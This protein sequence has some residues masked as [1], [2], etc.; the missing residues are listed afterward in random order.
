MD[1]MNKNIVTQRLF[2]KIASVVNIQF[3][4]H[5]HVNEINVSRRILTI[6]LFLFVFLFFC[7][8]F[9][10]FFFFLFFCFFFLPFLS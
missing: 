6:F 10:F 7:L 9:F 2:D 3:K 1:T 5:S 8:F 4:I